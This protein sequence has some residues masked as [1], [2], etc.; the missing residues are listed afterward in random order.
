M[1]ALDARIEAAIGAALGEPIHLTSRR[2]LGGGCINDAARIET[3]AGPFFV[4]SNGTPGALFSA[5]AAGLAAMRASGTSLAIPDVIAHEDPR[6][7][8]AGFL[9]TTY[10]EPG[11]REGDFDEALGRGLAE[12]HAA[13]RDTFGFDVDTYCGTT[14][15]PNPDVPRWIDFYRDHRIGHQLRLGVRAGIYD[16]GE[17]KAV[18]RLMARFDTLLDEAPPSLVHGDLWSGN[19][20]ADGGRP[21]LIDPAAAYAHPEME[22]GMMTLFGGF[23][24]RTYDA[25]E[26]VRPLDGWRERNPLYQLY[27]LMN[28]ALLFGGG[29]VGQ[30][31]GVVRRFA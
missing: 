26:A 8:A 4:K 23:S 7:G 29:Y 20:H 5:E 11:R 25:Y 24:R 16:R 6:P 2:A 19:L 27:H 28:H 17:A 3:T 18:E 1:N 13:T 15:Q 14:L 30:A 21:A 10:L 31:M 22:L 9:V 12:L